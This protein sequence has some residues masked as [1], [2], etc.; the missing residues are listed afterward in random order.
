MNGPLHGPRDGLA[1]RGLADAGRAHEAQDRRLAL[2]GQLA[3][4]QIFHDALL[5]LFEA[6]MVLLKYAARL[7][8]IDGLLLGQRPGQFDK[9]VEIGADHARLAACSGMRS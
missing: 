3:H 1:E 6:E 8:D 4:G 9:R 7:G 2:R 5:D